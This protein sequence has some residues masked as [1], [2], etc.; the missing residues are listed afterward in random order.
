MTPVRDLNPQNQNNGFPPSLGEAVP[1]DKGVQY[2][3]GRQCAVCAAS[4]EGYRRDARYCGAGCRSRARH[5]RAA[6]A[7]ERGPAEAEVVRTRALP[8][9]RAEACADPYEQELLRLV[10]KFPDL[11]EV[12]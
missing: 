6:H 4:L 12:A 8:E 7:H 5:A 10:R 1:L 2:S 3:N 11:A 9:K